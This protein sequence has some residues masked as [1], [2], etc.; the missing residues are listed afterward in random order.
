MHTTAVAD[1]IEKYKLEDPAADHKAGKFNEPA[2]QELYDEL[3]KQGESSYEGAI[4]VGLQIEDLDIAD[5]QKAL[6]EDVENKDIIFVYENLLRGSVNHLNAFWFHA[7]RNEI[8]YEPQ[9]ISAETFS[10]LI[11]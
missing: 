2:L 4:I 7:S 6:E 9:H 1:L 10:E 3:I 11:R 8:E 5:L